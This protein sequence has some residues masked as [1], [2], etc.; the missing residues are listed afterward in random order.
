LDLD[1]S[2]SESETRQERR[3]VVC[4]DGEKGDGVWCVEMARRVVKGNG[5]ATERE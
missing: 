4:G 1:K 2:E 3:G 5:K